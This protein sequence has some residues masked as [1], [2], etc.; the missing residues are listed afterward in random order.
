MD[1]LITLMMI[2]QLMNS[3]SDGT[4]NQVINEKKEEKERQID[5][6]KQEVLAL[7][8]EE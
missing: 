2:Q 3:P 7:L 6:L 1:D 8:E 5:K 4:N